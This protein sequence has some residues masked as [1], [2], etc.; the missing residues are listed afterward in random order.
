M[1]C[2]NKLIIRSEKS[3]DF[4]EIY[5]VNQLAFGRKNESELIS[6]LRGKSSFDPRLSLMALINKN[7]VWYSL[8]FPITS[9]ILALGPVAVMPDYQRQKIGTKLI[10]QGI[11]V[12]KKLNYSLITVIGYPQ[13]YPRFG[14][15]KASQYQITSNYEKIPDEAFMV[16]FFSDPS[17][18]LN[19]KIMFPEEY[20]I[21]D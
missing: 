3:A 1:I 19:T 6:V 7:C 9:K 8:L 5:K 15:K 4:Q 11:I 17:Q 13:Y 18:F 2:P 10:K 12:A 16:Y 21:A 20:H 14:F